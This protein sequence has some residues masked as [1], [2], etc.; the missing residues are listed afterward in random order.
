MQRRRLTLAL[1]VALL[2][3]PTTASAQMF[4]NPDPV[5]E[6]MWQEGMEN[7]QAY[8]LAQA[9]LDSIGPRLTGSPGHQAANDW[10]VAMYRRH[11]KARCW[12]GVPGPGARSGRG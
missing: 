4:P 7:S 6:R 9:L 5:L 2:A 11:S 3:T 12:P 10:L 8:A 1:G